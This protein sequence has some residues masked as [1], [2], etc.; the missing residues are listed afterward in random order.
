MPPEPPKKAIACV[1]CRHRKVRCDGLLPACSNCLKARVPCEESAGSEKKYIHELEA[2][3]RELEARLASQARPAPADDASATQAH[4]RPATPRIGP[5][6]PL[7]HEVGLLSLQ[8]ASSPKY[9]GPSS[10]VA[11][12]RLIFASAPHAQGLSTRFA[13]D[14]PQSHL[15]HVSSASHL[16]SLPEIHR[17]VA[18]YFDQFQHLY[19]FL[20][21]ALVDDL[22]EKCLAHPSPAT[23]SDMCMLFL[24]IAIGSRALE[25]QLGAD[26]ASATYLAASIGFLA[27]I[28]LHESIQAVQVL[29]L[30]VLSS[31]CFPGS[32]NAWFLTHAILASCL[33]LGL[34]RKQ[35][36]ERDAGRPHLRFGATVAAHDTRSGV[37]WSAYS[38]DRTLCTILGRPL[39]LRDEA[40]DIEFPGQQGSDEVDL[41]AIESASQ[42]LHLVDEHDAREHQ[43][44]RIRRE[45]PPHDGFYAANMSLRFD[46]IVA[47]VKLMIHRVAQSPKRFPWPTDFERWQRAVHASCKALLEHARQTLSRRA[48]GIARAVSYRSMPSIELK[49]HQCIMLLYR[50]SPVFPRPKP[51]ALDIC[52]DSA[53]E[54]IRIY[55]E[56]HRFGQMMNSWLTGHSIFVSAIT[57][58]YC[59][60]ISP[61]IRARAR[62][63]FGEHA[64]R[65]SETL[66]ALGKTWS[67]AKNARAKFDRLAEATSESWKRRQEPVAPES[68]VGPEQSRPVDT[69]WTEYNFDGS[70]DSTDA[71]ADELGDM[72]AWFDLEWFETYGAGNAG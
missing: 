19:P 8:A 24:I 55:H 11:F 66:E 57:M 16:P 26:F 68:A 58:L 18:A 2:R 13:T 71:F 39:T 53:T 50:P 14:L 52:F 20:D 1:R 23:D 4:T 70:F 37:F 67:V 49:Y 9:L 41:D 60:W 46:R 34:Q 6:Q 22:V 54:T 36:I 40:I 29:L 3:I 63:T 25:S 38:L 44:K 7:A 43:P 27:D 32:L 5:E 69:D 61:A 17:F 59:L 30:L 56:L 45:Q 35:P 21:D 31:F 65:C 33:D 47:E 10:G 51:E 12:A 64:K 42:V 28:P 15:S 48:G 72:S 62:D